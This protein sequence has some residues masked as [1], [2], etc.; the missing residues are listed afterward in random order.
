MDSIATL[1]ATLTEIIHSDAATRNNRRIAE[2]VY[3]QMNSVAFMKASEIAEAVNVSQA[4]VTRFVT[5]RLGF[6]RYSTFIK[7]IQ[8][9]VRSE[10]TAPDRYNKSS[11]TKSPHRAIDEEIS[12]LK[13]LSEDI[14][15]EQLKYL[16]KRISQAKTVYVL[17]FRTASHLARYF[18]FFLGKIHEDAHVDIRGGSE[19]FEKLDR[20]DPRTTVVFAY[21]FPRYPREMIN[22]VEFLKERK[23]DFFTM[24]DSRALEEYGVCDCTLVTPISMTT[25]FD[26]Y[27]TPFC[28]SNLLL[29]HIGRCDQKKT[30]RMLNNLEHLFKNRDFFYP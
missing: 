8:G 22:I 1:N 10:L 2:Y 12:H 17:G 24:T 20:L 14:S 16:A 3:T 21:I 4:A 18:H 7:L 26:S 29:D 13:N 6:D 19:L 9:G 5:Q 23:F 15:D 25:L 30:K 28:L 27:I 11:V